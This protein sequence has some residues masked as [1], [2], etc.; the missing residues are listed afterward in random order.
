[1][2]GV[3][4]LCLSEAVAAELRTL[5]WGEVRVAARP[6]QASLVALLADG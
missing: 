4:A 3:A 1:M 2:A 6:D 5:R